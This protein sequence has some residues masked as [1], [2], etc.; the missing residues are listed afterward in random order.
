MPVEG[1]DAPNLPLPDGDCVPHVVVRLKG[2]V[3]RLIGLSI[4]R[5]FGRADARSPP[6]SYAVI[7]SYISA[8]RFL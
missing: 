5:G 6:P 2:D 8:L 7:S 3:R 1:P 4:V